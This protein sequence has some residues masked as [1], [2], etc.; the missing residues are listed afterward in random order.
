MIYV[1]CISSHS[2]AVSPAQTSQ[3]WRTLPTVCINRK[4]SFRWVTSLSVGE[5][6]WF[7]PSVI[8]AETLH[9]P[10]HRSETYKWWQITNT[11]SG[12]RWGGSSG[13]KSYWSDFCLVAV[14]ETLLGATAAPH[15]FQRALQGVEKP[16]WL[17]REHA[18]FSGMW[19]G[20]L[21]EDGGLHFYNLGAQTWAT[22]L[23]RLLESYIIE[24]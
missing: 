14:V 10:R 23:L 13:L 15:L 12:C 24:S 2:E 17:C 16:A 19:M 18:V 4:T 8:T 1:W 6:R 3:N 11:W 20:C 9:S 21:G 22:F 7:W 5:L